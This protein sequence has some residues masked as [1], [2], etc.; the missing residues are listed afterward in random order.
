MSDVTKYIG[1]DVHKA[2]VAVAVAEGERGGEVRFVG[3]VANDDDE[4]RKLVRR[5]ATPGAT[6]SFCYEPGPCGYGL[7]RLL[8]KLGRPCIGAVRG[9]RGRNGHIGD[10]ISESKVGN[11]LIVDALIDRCGSPVTAI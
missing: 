6:L 11:G 9:Q 1:L 4:I 8:I 5:L 2:T 7:Q 10:C 3:T